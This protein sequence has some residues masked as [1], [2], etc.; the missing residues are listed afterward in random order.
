[1]L[2]TITWHEERDYKDII[3]EYLLIKAQFIKNKDYIITN[4]NFILHKLWIKVWEIW[5]KY[6]QKNLKVNL[7]SLINLIKFNYLEFIESK[8]KN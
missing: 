7:I 6:Y 1:M 8:I 2:N 3:W 5:Q 4:N